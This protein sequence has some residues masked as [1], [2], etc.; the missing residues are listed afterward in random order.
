MKSRSRVVFKLML[1]LTS[2]FGLSKSKA[3]DVVQVDSVVLSNRVGLENLLRGQLAGVLVKNWSGTPGL[4]STLNIR[5]IS[6][7]PSDVSTLPLVLVN[8]VPLIAS[9][10]A[11]T[12]INPLAYFSADQVDRIEVIKDAAVLA[13]YGVLAANGLVN[14]I[15]KEGN[16]GPLNVQA[17]AYAG[18]DFVSN[19]KDSFYNF[20]PAA[21]KEAYK[22]GTL[23][24]EQSAMVD[25]GGSY[26]SYRFGLNNY[27]S[28][29]GLK[30]AD[31]N[32]QSLFLNARYTISEAL[33][34]QFYNNFALANRNG[35]Y[36]GEY[37]RDLS[38]T[39][40]PDES[41]FMDDKRNIAVLSSLQLQYRFSPTWALSTK[42][43]LSYEGS[44]RDSY[45]PSTI[46]AGKIFAQ[47][48]GY[49]RQLLNLVTEL[50]H[51][52]DWSDRWHLDMV[53][54]HEIR[55]TDYR[56]TS[57]D[58]ERSLES[59]GSD[60]VKVVTGYNANQ[61]NAWA[62]KDLQKLVSFYG[63]WALNLDKKLAIDLSL[64]TD[65][66]SLYA[67]KWTLYPS[68]GLQYDFSD[69]LQFPIRAK[70]SWGR[71][72]ILQ[73]PEVYRGE[74]AAFGE[75]YSRNKLG[76]GQSYPAFRD[77]KSVVVSQ[78]DLRIST[79]LNSKT[80][81]S[82][83]Y[84]NKD[85]TDFTYK[86]YLSNLEGI[87]YRYENGAGLRIS[88]LELDFKTKWIDKNAF[89]WATQ[90]NIAAHDNQVTKLPE[91][92]AQTSLAARSALQKGDAITSIIAYEQ[93]EAQIIGN[94]SP[95]FFGGLGNSIRW[96]NL[97]LAFTLNY[98]QGADAALVSYGSR[99]PAKDET[100]SFPVAAGETPYFFKERQPD[101]S[102]IYQGISAIQSTSY[103]QLSNLMFAY[104][105][106]ALE[107]KFPLIKEVNLFA[108][109]ENLF[110]LSSYKGI[111]PDENINGIRRA[112][113]A[114]TG[115]PLPAS[116]V[117][118]FK[119]KF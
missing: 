45:V 23:I 74:L 90:F 14:I 111:N 99:Y 31:F 48:I 65:G 117:L 55:N 10:S 41:Q 1:M 75:Y 36:S 60:Y 116:W 67:K 115:T 110:T 3:Q 69:A 57:A 80:S 87:D 32:R 11:A 2:C 5:G 104:R 91:A 19:F 83:S 9:P 4:Q 37:A 54:G 82:L 40:I 29:G 114:L 79:D 95:K 15:V 84:F 26:G 33:S 49:K 25:G 118:G 30:D 58:G 7:D 24:Q 71:M 93:Q 108:R 85:Y 66:S 78:Y 101:G 28:A 43:G 47:S 94:S 35:R 105:L 46:T 100:A 113:L 109:G 70:A 88:G 52:H 77:A 64:R 97:S 38:K 18:A 13:R 12:G 50:T 61:M 96:N 102:L 56:I 89:T 51:Q 42:G 21:R 20:N 6:L 119:V 76:V 68:V 63:I 34:M 72:G 22:S 53:L 59:G 98:A 73:G 44:S 112:D 39:S 62:D 27:K 107:Q 16:V 103:I 92:I 86:R 81:L 8:G 106:R 17:S